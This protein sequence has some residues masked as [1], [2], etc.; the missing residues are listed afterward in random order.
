[1]E[2]EIMFQIEEERRK[3][4]AALEQEKRDRE[5]K[6]L[7]ILFQFTKSAQEDAFAKVMNEKV[8]KPPPKP[9]SVV[10]PNPNR[11]TV[12]QSHF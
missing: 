4:N 7:K 9:A 1:M 2:Y 8:T 11:P 12:N 6:G 5:A 3:E 10:P